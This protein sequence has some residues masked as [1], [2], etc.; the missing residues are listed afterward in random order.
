[1][2][3][4]NS[5]YEAMDKNLHATMSKVTSGLSPSALMAAYTDWA[6]HLASSPGKQA[7]LLEKSARKSAR[8]AGFLS[9]CTVQK[10]KKDSCIEPLPFDKR[11][12]D[13]AWKKWPFNIL[14]QSFLLNQQWWSN[15]TTGVHGV[16]QQHENVM[17][18]ATRQILDVFSPSKYLL[19]N[20]K[21][22]EQTT[23]EG[24][25]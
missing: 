17:E 3:K 11:F 18:F 13:P 23:T 5:T 24:G 16:T 6:V 22:I 19:T 21:L 10:G 1:M 8:L 14:Y 12:S 4:G 15:A 25:Q 20:P 7:H 9:D 2:K